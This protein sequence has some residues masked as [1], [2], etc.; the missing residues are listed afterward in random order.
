MK[1]LSSWDCII[2]ENIEFPLKL[3]FTYNDESKLCENYRVS[4]TLDLQYPCGKIS[5][6]NNKRP[7]SNDKAEFWQAGRFC[8]ERSSVAGIE[9]EKTQRA[10]QN[11]EDGHG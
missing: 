11:V 9:Y 2:D 6:Y 8:R 7:L 5:Q 10:E 3:V 4:S 1:E